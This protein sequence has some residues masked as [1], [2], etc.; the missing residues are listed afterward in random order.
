MTELVTREEAEKCL[1]E[2][3][4]RIER[5]SA[6]HDEGVV[7]PTILAALLKIR[8]Q[9]V[10]NYIKQGKIPAEQGATQKMMVHWQDAITFAQTYLNRKAD[11]QDKIDRQLRGED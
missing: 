10:Y 9:M 3:G 6:Q 8:P 2:R 5:F 4:H 1:L 11:K 7:S